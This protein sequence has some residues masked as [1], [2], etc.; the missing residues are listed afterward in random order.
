MAQILLHLLVLNLI[1]RASFPA[2]RAGGGVWGWTAP[3]WNFSQRPART[4]LGIGPIWP[5][6]M[7]FSPLSSPL[8]SCRALYSDKKKRVARMVTY[9]V[10]YIYYKDNQLYITAASLVRTRTLRYRKFSARG[11][12]VPIYSTEV[13][14]VGSLYPPPLTG[15]TIQPH[16]A[17]ALS[18][19]VLCR[20]GGGMPCAW[21]VPV[22]VPIFKAQNSE[23]TSQ[24]WLTGSYA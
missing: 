10:D 19:R 11:N 1:T 6:S 2:G 21:S 20:M 22:V 24:Y 14:A 3:F 16:A 12:T 7:T 9:T 13:C 17:Q 18:S 15:D 4:G 23:S 5:R 8:S